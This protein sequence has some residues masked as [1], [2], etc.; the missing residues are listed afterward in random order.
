MSEMW[1]SN[2]F[3]VCHCLPSFVSVSVVSAKPPP[4]L[5]LSVD[6]SELMT[7]FSFVSFLLLICLLCIGQEVKAE[8]E[9]KWDIQ[10][11]EDH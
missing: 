5:S 3:S 10:H 7:F 6:W 2:R 4:S 8:Y 1:K 9:R 11:Q